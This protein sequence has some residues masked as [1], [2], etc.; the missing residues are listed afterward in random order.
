MINPKALNHK[1]CAIC[2]DHNLS[3]FWDSKTICGF[4]WPGL[5]YE[6]L[7]VQTLVCVL[8][9]L[10]LSIGSCPCVF[11][12][13]RWYTGKLDSEQKSIWKYQHGFGCLVQELRA[14]IMFVVFQKYETSWILAGI[15]FCF[16][17]EF[18]GQITQGWDMCSSSHVWTEEPIFLM[19]GSG[20][21]LC[22]NEASN[23]SKVLWHFLKF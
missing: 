3:N 7:L 13:I 11:E 8:L 2:N 4:R 16:I 20:H 18:L 14:F 19:V 23:H 17:D 21:F 6:W 12:E 9:N 10:Q 22:T 1:P 15:A 5:R